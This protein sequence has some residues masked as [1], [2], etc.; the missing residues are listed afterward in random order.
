ML[1]REP[2]K[3]SEELKRGS[4]E[5]ASQFEGTASIWALWQELVWCVSG[6]ARNP[7]QNDL[8]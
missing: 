4:E 1:D 3:L 6:M 7:K 8:E 2:G 5:N